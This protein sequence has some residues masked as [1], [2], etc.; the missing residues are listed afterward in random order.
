MYWAGIPSL[1]LPPP[2]RRD[3]CQKLQN[4][5]QGSAIQPQISPHPLPPP[6]VV[7]PIGVIY[8][9]YM[10]GS[11]AKL[12]QCLS[13][14]LSNSLFMEFSLGRYRYCTYCTQ[15]WA[16]YQQR[17][18]GGGNINQSE[19]ARGIFSI[20][21]GYLS[22]TCDSECPVERNICGFLCRMRPPGLIISLCILYHI[23]NT[24]ILFMSRWPT[25]Y[26]Y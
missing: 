15:C 18:G 26:T 21:K 5:N 17:V 11:Q 14:H 3:R 12:M 25:Y 6:W 10:L 24:L 23:N 1:D 20:P 8:K 13:S 4:Y 22:G 9:E 19:M 7:P 2:P 16:S